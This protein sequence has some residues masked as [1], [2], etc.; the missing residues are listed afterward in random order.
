MAT[1]VTVDRDICQG[2]GLCH[3]TVARLFALS[4]EDGKAMVLLDPVPADLV[5]AAHRAV[6]GCPEQ[7]ITIRED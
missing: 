2:H 5:S 1:H 6:D 4:D 7:A 3:L